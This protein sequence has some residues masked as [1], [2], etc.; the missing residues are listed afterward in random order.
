[1]PIRDLLTIPEFITW[2]RLGRTKVYEE[3]AAGSLRAIKVGRRT[4]IKREDALAWLD[5]QPAMTTSAA[6]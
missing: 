4:F 1:M 2:C 3:I 5:S 6:Q